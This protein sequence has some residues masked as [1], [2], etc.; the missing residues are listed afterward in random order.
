VIETD[1]SF[2]I[3]R[4]ACRTPAGYQPF[5]EVEDLIRDHIR[6]ELQTKALEEIYSRTAI[7]SPYIDDVSSILH[8][9]AACC[10]PK[11]KDDAFAP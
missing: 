6:Q 5:E 7:E 3:V 10:P 9:T 4:V 1:H 2:R 8:R 11:A